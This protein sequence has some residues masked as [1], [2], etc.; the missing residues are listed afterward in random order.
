MNTGKKEKILEFIKNRSFTMEQLS[1]IC[2]A[3]RENYQDVLEVIKSHNKINSYLY[4]NGRKSDGLITDFIAHLSNGL[5][6]PGG[7]GNAAPDSWVDDKKVEHKA[8]DPDASKTHVAASR[9]FASN[10]GVPEYRAFLNKCQRSDQEVDGFISPWCYDK[11]DYYL[12]T[13]TGGG[14]WD[15]DPKTT[16][17]YFPETAVLKESIN[18]CHETKDGKTKRGNKPG[19]TVN[20]ETLKVSCPK[21]TEKEITNFLETNEDKACNL[22]PTKELQEKNNTTRIAA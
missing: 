13:G 20:F 14:K 17:L 15:G 22:S 9:Y 6:V 18:W 11:N 12:L 7:D 2:G 1:R 19:L 8:F 4:Q 5:F 3:S 21:I 16:L 10:S